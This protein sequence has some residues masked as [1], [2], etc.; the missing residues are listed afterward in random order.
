MALYHPK[1][2]RS[3]GNKT[4]PVLLFRVYHTQVSIHNIYLPVKHWFS[5]LYLDDMAGLGWFDEREFVCHGP[6]LKV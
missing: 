4:Q 3:I 2:A 1:F 5:H 6:T